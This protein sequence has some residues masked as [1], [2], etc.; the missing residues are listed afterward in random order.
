MRLQQ[1]YRDDKRFHP[2]IIGGIL[3]VFLTSIAVFISHMEGISYFDSFYA[4]F[5]TYSCIGFGDIDIFVSVQS[6]LINLQLFKSCIFV[7]VSTLTENLLPLNLV[8]SFDLRK[9]YPHLGL[10]DFVCVDLLLAGKM[11]CQEILSTLHCCRDREIAKERKPSIV[12]KIY[13]TFQTLRALGTRYL[14][15]CN[16]Q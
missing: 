5:I 3:M 9:L 4:A 7:F 11:R 16:I 12:R 1:Q 2:A 8:Q 13:K 15:K 14:S 6:I 10:Y